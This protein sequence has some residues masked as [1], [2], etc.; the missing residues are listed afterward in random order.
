MAYNEW[1]NAF[2][3]VLNVST[4]SQKVLPYHYKTKFSSKRYQKQIRNDPAQ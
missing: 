4:Y 1:Y 2:A 3:I